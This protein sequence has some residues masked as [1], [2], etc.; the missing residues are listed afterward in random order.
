VRT[1]PTAGE[2]GFARYGSGAGSCRERDQQILYPYKAAVY[3]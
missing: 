2:A 1:G 3:V